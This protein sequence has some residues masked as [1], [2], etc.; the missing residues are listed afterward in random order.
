MDKPI[1]LV[2]Q[3]DWRIVIVPPGRVLLEHRDQDSLGADRWNFVD[4]RS[5]TIENGQVV[6]EQSFP[7]RG[8]QALLCRGIDLLVWALIKEREW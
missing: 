4:G 2:C 3:Y 8:Q 1:L 6:V 5:L 7:D